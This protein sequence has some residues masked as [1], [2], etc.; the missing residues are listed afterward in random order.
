MLRCGG[1]KVGAALTNDAQVNELRHWDLLHRRLRRWP[2]RVNQAA[3]FSRI[4]RAERWVPKT[5]PN[6]R[7]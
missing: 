2:A 1:G 4:A 3:R 6:V 5:S 7:L